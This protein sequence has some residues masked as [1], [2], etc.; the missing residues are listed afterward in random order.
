MK[1]YNIQKFDLNLGD[2][3]IGINGIR[4]LSVAFTKL[5]TNIR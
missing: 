5:P 2:N 1:C 4:D 3:K